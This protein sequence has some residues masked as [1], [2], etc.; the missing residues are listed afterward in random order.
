MKFQNR[1]E[2][3]LT[4]GLT[5]LIDVVFILLIFFMVTTTFDRS[6]ELAIDLPSASGDPSA[7]KE[8]TLEIAIDVQGQ[9]FINQ[10]KVVSSAPETFFLALRKVLDGRKDVPVLI[11]ADAETPHHAVV[12]A[13][14]TVGKLGLTRL[15]IATSIPTE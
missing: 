14:D 5:P 2:E 3:E 10:V 12:T 4:I 13:M 9:F 8:D 6:S 15:S 1:K 7:A 11:Q